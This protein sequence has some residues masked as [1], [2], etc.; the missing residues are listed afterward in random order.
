M[1]IPPKIS[2]IIPVY[3]VEKYIKKSLQSLL[4]Q[5]F[6]DFEA[7]IVDDGS[8]DQSIPRAKKLVGDDPRFIFLEK[9][10]GGQ[11]SARN[12]GLDYAKGQYIAFLDPDDYMQADCLQSCINIISQD[13]TID[14]VLFGHN[15]VTV[16]EE[17]IKTVQPDHEKYLSEMDYLLTKNTID[18]SVWSKVYK[19]ELFNNTRFKEGLLY[20]DMLITV[21]LLY[22]KKLSTIK[23]SLYNYVQRSGST[24]HSYNTNVM[25]DIFYIYSFFEDFLKKNRLWASHE[26]YYIQSYLKNVFLGIAIHLAKYS[27]Y[28]HKDITKLNSSLN[29][30]YTDYYNI[31]KKRLLST[32]QKISLLLYKASPVLFKK[33]IL[34]KEKTK[35][36]KK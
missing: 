12:M 23:K 6:T 3:G 24:M 9:E 31:V 16:K 36:W 21:E 28:Y 34:L 14:I 20:E 1:S 2:I 27:P 32:S 15:L 22:G 10:N 29:K 25:K 13:P 4:D 30:D 17:I 7:I 5:T 11:S 8:L 18:Y 26:N 19:R 35:I 33:L